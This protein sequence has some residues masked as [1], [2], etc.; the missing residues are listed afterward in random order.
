MDQMDGGF[1]PFGQRKFNQEE[2]GDGGENGEAIP[3]MRILLTLSVDTGSRGATNTASQSWKPAFPHSF[4]NHDS[5]LDMT[6]LPSPIHQ[7]LGVYWSYQVR[8]LHTIFLNSTFLI[9]TDQQ[10]IPRL[11]KNMTLTERR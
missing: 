8:L 3:K 1:P 2:E 4:G 7:K 10:S 5:G 11:L 9:L 6:C